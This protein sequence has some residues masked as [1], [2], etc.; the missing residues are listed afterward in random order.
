MQACIAPNLRRKSCQPPCTLC[1]GT[2]AAQSPLL[3]RLRPGGAGAHPL[4]CRPRISIPLATPLHIPACI[5]PP[6]HAHPV[7]SPADRVA[8]GHGGGLAPWGQGPVRL[9]QAPGL[10]VQQHAVPAAQ[11]L[12]P[13]HPHLPHFL[14]HLAARQQQQGRQAVLTGGQQ[15]QRC[16]SRCWCGGRGSSCQ[17]SAA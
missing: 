7:V 6:S 9:G 4:L 8:P 16:R 13:L 17:H 1:A 5:E 10:Q 15:H 11:Q 14:R 2:D 12:Q 3:P